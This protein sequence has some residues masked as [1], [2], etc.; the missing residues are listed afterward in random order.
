MA[1]TAID[2]I[3]A[4]QVSRQNALKAGVIQIFNEGRL[5]AAM[6]QLA[7]QG[8]ALSYNIEEKLNQGFAFRGLNEGYSAAGL[9]ILNP[10]TESLRIIG[11]D[12]DT[13]LML[14]QMVGPEARAFQIQSKL[15]AMRLYLEKQLIQGDSSTNPKAFDGLKVRIPSGSSQ[16]ITNATNGAGLS[17][18]KLDELIDAVDASQG[19]LVLVMN[20][21]VRRRLAA[22]NRVASAVGNIRWTQD[23][24]GQRITEYAGI[25]IIEIDHDETGAQILPFSET[26]GNT[27]ANTSVYAVVAGENAATLLTNGGLQVRD[28]GE[29]NDKPVR[30]IRVEMALGMA[31]FHPRAIARLEG[32]TNA[33]VTA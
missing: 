7:I 5:Y 24:L 27:S 10:Q 22:A 16:L 9:G 20:R 26:C 2:I 14:E 1:T 18:D 21:T 13:D 28:L 3:S 29:V 25:P 12:L 11:G 23:A 4:S 8:N 33:A 19:Q 17:L 32:V 15:K 31:V 6:P 30:R